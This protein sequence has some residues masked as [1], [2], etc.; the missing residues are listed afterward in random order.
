MASEDT[1]I[2]FTVGDQE[3]V[4]RMETILERID[5]KLD[6]LPCQHEPPLCTQ[7]ARLGSLE[8]TRGRWYKGLI[9]LV[10][11]TLVAGIVAI[12]NTVAGLK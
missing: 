9:T 12:F 2:G 5:E 11:G 6:Q 3:R 1:R 10:V 8:K 4:V 7:E